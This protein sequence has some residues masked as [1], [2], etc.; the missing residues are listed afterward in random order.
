NSITTDKG[1]AVH[2]QSGRRARYGSLVDRA[3]SL[4][5]PKTISLKD[6]KNFKLLGKST[7]RLDIPEKVNGKASFGIHGH[8]PALLTARVG[9]CP[10]FGGTVESF[11][12]D[13]AKAIAGV[14]NVV[15]ISSGIAVVADNYWAASKG[16]QALEVKWNEGPLA[17]L[18]SADITKKYAALAQ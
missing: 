17:K 8:Q 9:R 14:R 7:P 13:K 10:V 6:P 11:N 12:A 1:E 18:N 15:K 3:A 2:T 4:P 5:A 16:A